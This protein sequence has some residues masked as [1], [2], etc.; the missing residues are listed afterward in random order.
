MPADEGFEHRHQGRRLNAGIK[1][2]AQEPVTET[3]MLIVPDDRGA[4]RSGLRRGEPSERLTQRAV[5][6][7]SEKLPSVYLALPAHPEHRSSS[8]A[9]IRSSGTARGKVSTTW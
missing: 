4:G 9:P 6:F 1:A 2:I 7:G 5:L 3:E 8:N